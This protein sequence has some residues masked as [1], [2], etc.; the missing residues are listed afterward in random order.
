MSFDSYI[1]RVCTRSDTQYPRLQSAVEAAFSCFYGLGGGHDEYEKSAVLER[2]STPEQFT[3]FTVAW[4]DD[5]N[6][7]R[8]NRGYYA[9]SL[10]CV[11]GAGRLCFQSGLTADRAQALF[12]Y[13]LLEESL[14]G[15]ESAGIFCGADCDCA[16][17]SDGESMRFCQSFLSALYR[18]APPVGAFVPLC[19]NI[20]D[21]ELGYLAGQQRALGAG[22]YS[23]NP[24]P[25]GAAAAIATAVGSGV[26]YFARE[27]LRRA[28]GDSLD[29]KTVA[30]Y[31]SG[32]VAARAWE[33]A[34]CMGGH[35]PA[36][37]S[38]GDTAADVYLLCAGGSPIDREAAE[39]MLSHR[40]DGICEAVS[41]ACTP[42]GAQTLTQSGVLFAP[43]IAAGS[44]ISLLADPFHPLTWQTER[45]LR[46]AMNALCD[47]VWEKGEGNLFRGAH[48][49]AVENAAGALLR[50]GVL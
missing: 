35:M 3:V 21:R 36:M 42:E 2:L 45:E 6:R 18:C 4:T 47:R 29:G 28:F 16:L 27:A 15:K 38:G 22:A 48:I 34:A 23:P 39:R 50:R 11:G 25:R 41:M 49:A 13:S 43:A 46:A 31:G 5:L 17:L 44:G 37:Q 20:S 14:C 26:C 24:M 10:P 12:F 7:V 1:R 9:A 40:P 32:A 19:P 33:E 8:T 30:V